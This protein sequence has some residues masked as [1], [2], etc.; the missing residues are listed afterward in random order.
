M[1]IQKVLL[2]VRSGIKKLCPLSEI[3][4]TGNSVVSQMKVK[5]PNNNSA[6]SFVS[7]NGSYGTGIYFADIGIGGISGKVMVNEKLMPFHAQLGK[8]VPNAYSEIAAILKGY[9]KGKCKDVTKEVL[10]G[11]Y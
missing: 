3:K 8:D 7:A 2:D 11:I 5:L 4:R 1:A 6:F 9:A 10:S